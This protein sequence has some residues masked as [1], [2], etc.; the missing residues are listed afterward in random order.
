M[1]LNQG[2]FRLRENRDDTHVGLST[3]F[4]RAERVKMRQ[5]KALSRS[6]NGIVRAL[7]TQEKVGVRDEC[8]VRAEKK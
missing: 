1:G 5:Q 3:L 4:V 7:V 8:E 6:N 2:R